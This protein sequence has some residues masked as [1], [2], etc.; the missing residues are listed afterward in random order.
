MVGQHVCDTPLSTSR[1]F[2][3]HVYICWPQTK[4]WH[5]HKQVV[6]IPLVPRDSAL[7]VKTHL[8]RHL[9]QQGSTA[10]GAARER[11]EPQ[12]LTAALRPKTCCKHTSNK[13]SP[14]MHCTALHRTAPAAAAATQD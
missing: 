14:T 4:D 7:V 1:T 12:G 3:S 11:D 10:A 9:R 5:P 8:L 2:V 13:C 6:A